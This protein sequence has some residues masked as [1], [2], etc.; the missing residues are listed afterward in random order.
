MYSI[1]N[2]RVLVIVSTLRGPGN[3]EEKKKKKKDT[4]T[5]TK[6]AR[7]IIHGFKNIGGPLPPFNDVQPYMSLS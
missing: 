1:Y 2:I 7:Y 5:V 6:A 3:T 4:G